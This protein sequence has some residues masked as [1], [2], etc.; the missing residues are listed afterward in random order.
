MA[1]LKG[2]FEFF[3]LDFRTQLACHIL[4]QIEIGFLLTKTDPGSILLVMIVPVS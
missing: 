2:H 4:Q 3:F 1:V